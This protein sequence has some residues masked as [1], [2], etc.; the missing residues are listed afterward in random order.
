MSILELLAGSKDLARTAPEIG[1]SLS[2]SHEATYT[3]LVALESAGAVRVV[4][5]H[6][7]RRRCSGVARWELMPAGVRRMFR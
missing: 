1:A 3:E 4:V 6:T 2:M 7:D 5:D